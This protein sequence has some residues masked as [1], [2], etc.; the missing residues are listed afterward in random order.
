MDIPV[1]HDDQHGT[2]VIC[3][4]GLINALHLSGKKIEDV[5]I[6]LNGAGAAGIAC[7][8]LLKAM[9]ARHENCIVCDTKGVI[10]QG[11]TEGMN[12]WKS[13]HA[14]KTE[15]AHAGRGD[16]GRRRVPGR[17]G[18]G[19][20]DEEMVQH[21]R[22]PGDLR[23]GQPRSRNHAGRGRSAPMRSWPPGGRIIPTRSTT[24]SAFPI[25][26]AARWTSAPAPSTTR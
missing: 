9:G 12:Q 3:A 15:A 10:Y 24:S 7:I 5:P 22:Q 4:A 1:F 17:V 25:S 14:V 18:Q 23:H 16:E 20:G 26:S 2:A 13:A 8:E 21:G 6:V 11:R 19:R